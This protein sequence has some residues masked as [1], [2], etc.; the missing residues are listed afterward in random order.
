LALWGS[1]CAVETA[2]STQAAEVPPQICELAA[3]LPP[4]N[5]CSL[6]CDPEALEG[7]M[8]ERGDVIGRCYEFDCV[9]PDSSRVSVG[10]C[11]LP[12]QDFAHPPLPQ[13][14]GVSAEPSS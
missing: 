1:G 7:A 2:T 8:R 12:E 11:L 4:E 5:L 14:V 6:I 10:I 13:Y 3:G 9:M